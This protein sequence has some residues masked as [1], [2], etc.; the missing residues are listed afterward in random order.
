MAPLGIVYVPLAGEGTDVWVPVAAKPFGDG[1][2]RLGGPQPPDQFWRF[3]AGY[4]VGV[5]RRAFGADGDGWAA[6]ESFGACPPSFVELC[7]VLLAPIGERRLCIF[8][9]EDGLFQYREDQLSDDEDFG[10]LWREG[11]PLSGL[12]GSRA[13]ALADAPAD[14]R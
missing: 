7:D 14:Y 2:Y 3:P 8:R 13:A 6:T 5:V 4:V 1:F 11:Y 9:R 10:L 12:F